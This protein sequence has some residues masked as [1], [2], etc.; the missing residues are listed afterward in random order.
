[1]PP[2]PAGSHQVK[3]S[4]WIMKTHKG[5]AKRFRVGARGRLRATCSNANHL[6]S[7]RSAK[8]RRRVRRGTTLTGALADHVRGLL[9][10]A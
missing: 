1:M 7:G 3:G 4:V 8:R 10:G 6:K 9:R 5:S 2:A